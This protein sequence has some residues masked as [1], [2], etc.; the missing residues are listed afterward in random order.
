VEIEVREPVTRHVLTM[1]QAE[2]W[3]QGATPN[4]AEKVKE[5]RLKALLR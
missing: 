1:M 3:L 4:P 5:E 2:R